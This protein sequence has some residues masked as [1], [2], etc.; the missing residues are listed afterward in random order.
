M[1]PEEHV[2]EIICEQFPELCLTQQSNDLY[3]K[4]EQIADYAI[5]LLQKKSD[6]E[7]KSIT[8]VMLDLHQHCS[9]KVS[10]AIE[11]VFIYK[12]GTFVTVS[13]NREELMKLLPAAI[14]DKMVR[15]MIA[16]NI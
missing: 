14:K 13:E 16:S 8:S 2:L 9:N 4:F 15:Q 12:L 7:L 11:N 3:K 5:N 1:I 10:I 6:N